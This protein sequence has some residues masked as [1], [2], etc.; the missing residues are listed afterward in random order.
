MLWAIENFSSRTPLPTPFHA[1]T[2]H[3]FRPTRSA[4]NGSFQRLLEFNNPDC[5]LFFVRFSLYTGPPYKKDQGAEYTSPYGPAPVGAN[6]NGAAVN[7]KSRDIKSKDDKNQTRPL[8]AVGNERSRISWW[9]LSRLREGDGTGEDEG[10]TGSHRGRG[11][12]RGRGDASLRGRRPWI[13]TDRT[14]AIAAMAAGPVSI[15]ES[16]TLT[17]ANH[18]SPSNHNQ[19][20]EPSKATSLSA[21]KPTSESGFGSAGATPS[22]QDPEKPATTAAASTA[23]TTQ[24]RALSEVHS[25]S[26]ATPG[27]GADPMTGIERTSAIAMPSNHIDS[28]SSLQPTT[29]PNTSQAAGTPSAGTKSDA[30]NESKATESSPAAAV[31]SGSLPKE[32]HGPR[33][34]PFRP[35]PA[36]RSV[37]VPK[38]N[39]TIRQIAFSVGG[40][41]MVAVGDQGIIA[42]FQ[43]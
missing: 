16:A 13:G 28:S 1:P 18:R 8:L 5:D 40:E 29:T 39:F 23:T 42:L 20:G 12:K 9:D 31:E 22:G 14:A 32:R 21:S 3:E 33:S 36:H 34:D 30:T 15:A 7:D 25:A 43:R 35:L 37:V 10:H 38:I 6:E 27:D 41:Y 4:W 2:T 19:Q 17:G 26:A 11:G 24:T